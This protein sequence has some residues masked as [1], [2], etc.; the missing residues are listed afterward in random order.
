MRLYT[1]TGDAGDTSLFGGQR[2]SKADLRVEA[3]GT[4]DEV[5]A[6]LGVVVATLRASGGTVPG[7]AAARVDELERIQCDLFR[8][9]AELATPADGPGT[10]PG[11]PVSEADVQRLERWIDARDAECAPLRT[12]ILPG[13]SRTAAVLHHARTVARRAER[14]V[15]SLAA[16]TPIRGE[17]VRYLNRLSDLL[18]A[19]ARAENARLQVGETPWKP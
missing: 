12:F 9:G 10:I 16:A 13:G 6:L 15:V 19:V 8:V 14:R 1:K 2:V 3:Y 17:V 5:N 11:S 18:F 4:V 7:A